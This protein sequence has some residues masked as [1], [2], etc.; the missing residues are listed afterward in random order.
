MPNLEIQELK[1]YMIEME[2]RLMNAILTLTA[3]VDEKEEK[4]KSEFRDKI[5]ELSTWLEKKNNN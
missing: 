1:Q 4:K 3:K 5:K 2:S